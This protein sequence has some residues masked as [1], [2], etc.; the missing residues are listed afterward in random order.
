MPR[1]CKSRRDRGCRPLPPD[2]KHTP[3]HLNGTDSQN[4]PVSRPVYLGRMFL[5]SAQTS[6][7]FVRFLPRLRAMS[8]R[9]SGKTKTN[10]KFEAF[11]SGTVNSRALKVSEKPKRTDLT[12]CRYLAVFLPLFHVRPPR[13]LP[14]LPSFLLPP[15]HRG[16]RGL[17]AHHIRFFSFTPYMGALSLP[18][19]APGFIGL[20]PPRPTSP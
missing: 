16:G 8:S 19:G 17:T 10:A 13:I 9:S 5:S 14:V 2:K 6:R 3:V 1:A 11:S 15:L 12:E 20:A 4:K 7:Q 18:S